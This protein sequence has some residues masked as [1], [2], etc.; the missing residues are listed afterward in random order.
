MKLEKLSQSEHEDLA[1]ALFETRQAYIA[2]ALR[3]SS[4]YG[5]TRRPALIARRIYAQIDQLR[6]EMEAQFNVEFGAESGDPYYNKAS[7]GVRSEG[8]GEMES[9]GVIEMGS[10]GVKP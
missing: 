7:R 6:L 2:L 10:E 3:L 5:P 4:A 9:R 8:V 1:R